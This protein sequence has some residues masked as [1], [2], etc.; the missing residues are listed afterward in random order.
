LLKPLR[1]FEPFDS[2]VLL[3]TPCILIRAHHL[4]VA[5]SR[6][7]ASISTRSNAV[8]LAHRVKAYGPANDG[9][10]CDGARVVLP[11]YH[12]QPF[13]QLLQRER[14]ASVFINF[15]SSITEKPGP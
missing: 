15:I 9:S 14:T 1:R 10:P 13:T 7:A 5:R 8:D 3:L 6:C 4:E 12:F 2:P 11:T